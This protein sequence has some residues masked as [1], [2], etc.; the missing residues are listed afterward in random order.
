MVEIN[1]RGTTTINAVD[2]FGAFFDANYAYRF[3]PA[4]HN[5]V[6]GQLREADTGELIS[7]AFHFPLG[8]ARVMDDP[9]V[10][11]SLI[12]ENGDFAL[13]LQC[14]RFAQTIA[15]DEREFLP[16]RNYLHLAPG[17]RRVVPLRRLETSAT[18]PHGSVAA[19]NSQ[20]AVNY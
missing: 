3:G 20:R 8:R 13:A 14:R 10:E 2:L 7:E 19:L 18:R 1:A 15:I 6:V 17:E 12:E 9:E 11:A 16:M 4:A 5:I